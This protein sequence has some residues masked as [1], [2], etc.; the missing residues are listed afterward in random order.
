MLA[1]VLGTSCIG[2]H[3]PRTVSMTFSTN[4]LSHNNGAAY[5]TN[6]VFASVSGT[7][8]IGIDYP[9]TIGMPSSSNSVSSDG[10]RAYRANLMLI[11]INSTSRTNINYPFTIGMACGDI[12]LYYERFIAHRAMHTLAFSILG[13]SGGNSSIYN[14]GMTNC[15]NT[16]CFPFS[17][18]ART[19]FFTLDGAGC[20][21]NRQPFTKR[22]DVVIVWFLRSV[23]FITR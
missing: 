19:F 21:P 20:I 5:G 6:L 7:S 10:C 16:L 14:P 15:I 23:S 8:R 3:N 13:T 2:V 9:I 17:A 4:N 11:A 1:A 18:R 22:V 12:V